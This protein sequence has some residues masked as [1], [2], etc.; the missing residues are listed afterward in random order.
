MQQVNEK[1]TI[2]EWLAGATMVSIMLLGLW[3][4][5]A[6]MRHPAL[7]D[8]PHR[9]ED[10]HSGVGTDKFSKH[11]DNHLPWRGDLIA[12]ANAGRF[13]LTRGAGDQVRLGKDEWLF[14]VE[15]LEFHPQSEEHLAQRVVMVKLIEE[16]LTKQGISLL[17]VPVPDKARI[18]AEKTSQGHY[19]AWYASRYASLV[20]ALRAQG[21]PTVD[22]VDALT[23]AAKDGF[24]YYRTDTHWNQ[25]GAHSVAKSVARQVQA[26]G[27]SLPVTEFVTDSG[28]QPTERVGDLL[29]MMGLSSVPNWARPD[30]DWE[31][32]QSTRKATAS[33]SLGLLGDASVPVVLVGTSYSLRANFHGQLQEQLKAEVLNVAKDGAGFIQS[34]N[35]Y[36]KD[37]AFKTAPPKLI[38]W[39]IPERVFSPALTE[40][41]RKA[42][43]W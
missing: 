9:W 2:E 23:Q 21:I 38:V 3:Q 39:E 17:I 32:P 43:P 26:S 14:S 36:L 16:M 5:V 24:V 7:A 4:A 13:V 41:E 1:S 37:D 19:P 35:E 18:H 33:A 12:W 25:A 20:Q 27:L 22:V 28:Q 31:T 34:M 30:P 15:E 11:L 42:P 10:I 6:S 40:L 8:V 29:N